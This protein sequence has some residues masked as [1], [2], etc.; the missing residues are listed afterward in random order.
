MY[1]AALTPPTANEHTMLCDA[2]A[3]AFSMIVNGVATSVSNKI[4]PLVGVNVAPPVQVR[5]TVTPPTAGARLGVT[6][7][8]IDSSA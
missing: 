1:S 4:D 6:V 2:T 3:G 8:G 5:V 7:S